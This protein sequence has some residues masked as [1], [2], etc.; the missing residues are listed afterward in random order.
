MENIVEDIEDES[1]AEGSP[2]NSQ[3]YEDMEGGEVVSS[4]S[5]VKHGDTLSLSS[6]H[7]THR[8]RRQAD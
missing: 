4:S 6:H 5:S 7:K 2:A 1:E 3:H 8:H